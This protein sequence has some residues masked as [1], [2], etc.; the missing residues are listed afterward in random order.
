MKK[1]I[2]IIVFALLLCITAQA[3]ALNE[4]WFNSYTGMS[5]NSIG[6]DRQD[7]NGYWSEDFFIIY[8][9]YYYNESGDLIDYPTVEFQWFTPP[10]FIPEIEG[11][12][13]I[14]G[15]NPWDGIPPL[16]L[17][18]GRYDPDYFSFHIIEEDQ[19]TLP[20][21]NS[22]YMDILGGT[23]YVWGETRAHYEWE[24]LAF[25]FRLYDETNPSRWIIGG[26]NT[27][28]TP[29][30]E[31]SSMLLLGIGLLGARAYKKRKR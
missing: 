30:P 18:P 7:Y 9:T 1:L 23:L 10:G 14:P 31:P 19:F 12:P 22:G 13:Y 11:P 28:F 6:L 20:P 26:F 25:N 15:P 8:H 3:N 27:P 21:V 5:F 4:L 17:T 16:S 2:F 24:S 29:V